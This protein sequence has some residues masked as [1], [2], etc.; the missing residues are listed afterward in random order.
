MNQ[1][2]QDYAAQVESA[3]ERFLPE[4]MQEYSP[5]VEAMRYSLLGG[6]KRIRAILVLEFARLAGISAE[7]A[8]PFACGIEMVHAYS[9]I[10]DDLPCMDNDDF[11]RG[12]P[13]CHRQFSEATAL[14]AGDGLLNHSF[15]AIT[16]FADKKALGA[17][18]VLSALGILAEA[19][20]YEGMI[21]GQV[22]DLAGEGKPLTWEQLSQIYRLKTGALIQAA[23]E[24]GWALGNKEEALRTEVRR[25]ANSLGL[26]FQ[27]IDDILDEMGDP[28]LLGKPTGSDLQQHKSTYVTLFGLEAAKKQAEQLTGTALD[29]LER[30]SDGG[31][32]DV[33]FL[34][35]LT[36]QLLHREF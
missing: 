23:C 31:R 33:R 25:Y 22:L 16:R 35:E 34:R 26:C 20:G 13:S 11:R 2:Q 15:T 3:L 14:L 1:L 29:A 5:V 4:T 27:I 12:K 21:G 17:E 18:R 7:L 36:L 9:L 6:G 28:A 24:I 32:R 10:H 8:M 30:L 19:A